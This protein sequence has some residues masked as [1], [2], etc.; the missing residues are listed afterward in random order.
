MLIMSRG[1]EYVGRKYME[2]PISLCTF[3][4]AINLKLL[5]KKSSFK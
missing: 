5:P 1:Y 3:N 2:Y 4:F